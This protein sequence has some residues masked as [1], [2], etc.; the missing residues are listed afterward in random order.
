ME[1]GEKLVTWTEAS[2]L[3]GWHTSYGR[4]YLTDRRLIFQGRRFPFS[5]APLGHR[6][7]WF[8]RDIEAAGSARH[9]QTLFL[10]RVLYVEVDGRLHFFQG[11][12]TEQWLDHLSEA[13][14]RI[15]N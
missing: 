3:H 12:S 7:E 1:E 11:S 13:G 5:V 2:N 4:L 9:H 8:L 6:H 10:R 14:V 15:E